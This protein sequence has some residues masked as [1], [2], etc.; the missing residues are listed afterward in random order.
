MKVK[1]SPYGLVNMSAATL[2]PQRKEEMKIVD[3]YGN[4]LGYQQGS[5]YVINDKSG[6]R[7]GWINGLNDI[8]NTYGTKVGE[9]RSNGV[10][11]IYGN[12]VG[13]VNGDNI[14]SLLINSVVKKR[15]PSF[16][17]STSSSSSGGGGILGYGIFGVIIYGFLKALWSYIKGPFVEFS[18]LGETA[19]RKEW[20]GT[21]IRSILLSLLSGGA[22]VMVIIDIFPGVAGIIIATVLYLSF[23]FLPIIAVSIRRMHDI[24]K[25]GWWSLIP[26]VGF[27]MCGFFPGKI[28]ENKYI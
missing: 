28:E 26:I 24:G 14:F 8:I 22:L 25:N 2:T 23:G 16:S 15:S 1:N 6:N 17:S 10:F 5:E 9:L 21:C 11:D 12:R 7:I 27:V 18:Y 4:E 3:S 13:D 20:W 19:A